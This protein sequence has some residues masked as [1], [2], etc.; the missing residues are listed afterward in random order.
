[1]GGVID[2]TLARRL[3]TTVASEPPRPPLRVDLGDLSDEAERLVGG[4]T[5]LVPS[6]P[7]PRAEAVDRRSWIDANLRTIRGVVD[8]LSEKVGSSMGPMQG[9][10]RSVAGYVLAA[11]VGV[12]FGFMAQRVLGQYEL[13]LLEPAA[14]PRLLYVAPN[15]SEAIDK[16]EAD[17]EQFLRWVALHEVTHALQFGGVPWLR[18]HMAGMMR[19]LLDKVQLN[20]NPAGAM[21]LPDTKDLKG[22]VD[23]VRKGDLL[24]VVTTPEQRVM[25]DR[26]QATMAVIE[27]Y[28]E[29][30]M[31]EVGSRVLPSL[32]ELRAAMEKR[33]ATASPVVRFLQRLLGLEMKL[34]QYQQGKRFC[35]AVVAKE[36]IEG[37][38]RVWR[39]P[40]ALPT[41]AELDD[42]DAW[43]ERT[44]V[45]A[46]TA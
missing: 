42:P 25:L 26:V 5:R 17:R 24:S 40:D 23:Q 18:E 41:L 30:V 3:A 6:L 8:P 38:N 11:E 37:L 43:R 9:P 1:M 4:Y 15:L 2:W 28:A 13:A 31:D 22:I 44:K 46:L 10:M 29:H 14:P 19:E 34:R 35:D 16:F 12:V 45:L 7:L 21:K 33:R 39:S 20:V 36:G 27:G 32:P